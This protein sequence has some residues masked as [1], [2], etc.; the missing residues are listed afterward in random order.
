M[1]QTPTKI[2]FFLALFCPDCSRFS[3]TLQ[4]IFQQHKAQVTFS[5]PLQQS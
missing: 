2:T 4:S 1:H 3:F 5:S